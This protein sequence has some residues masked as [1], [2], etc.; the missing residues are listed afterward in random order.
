MTEVK[1]EMTEVKKMTEVKE[2]SFFTLEFLF[3]LFFR[4]LNIISLFIWKT[5]HLYFIR[6]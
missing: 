2:E 5:L 3:L 1:E 4:F 6:F